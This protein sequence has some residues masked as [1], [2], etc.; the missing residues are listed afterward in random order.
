M[1]ILYKLY[2]HCLFCI[3]YTRQIAWQ[4]CS[5]YTRDTQ[6]T[7][8]YNSWRSNQ[9]IVSLLIRTSVMFPIAPI[10][11]RCGQ[12]PKNEKRNQKETFANAA[13]R[14]WSDKGQGFR[15]VRVEGWASRVDANATAGLGWLCCL[16]PDW[17][18]LSFPYQLYR[19]QVGRKGL[20]D[21]LPETII[22][23]HISSSNN[24][25]NK[26]YKAFHW[27]LFSTSSNG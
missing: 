23:V 3:T 19:G 14:H 27:T 7:I 9:T 22:T 8:V 13:I 5:L 6:H 2:L 18:R 16:V 26:Q 4:T 24:L 21:R 1:R 11:Q 10:I 25:I 12:G 17:R 15:G 20:R